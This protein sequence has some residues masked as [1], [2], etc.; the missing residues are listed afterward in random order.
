MNISEINFIR[1]LLIKITTNSSIK[2]ITVFEYNKSEGILTSF[3]RHRFDLTSQHS[4]Y[5]W[6][7]DREEFFKSIESNIEYFK[8]IGKCV[9]VYI[10]YSFKSQIFKDREKKFVFRVERFDGKRFSIKEIKKAR[11]II[12][13]EMKNFYI[14]DFEDL[15]DIYSRNINIAAFLG[16][17]FAR[18]IRE[19]E[20]FKFIIRVLEGFFAFDRI[21]LY[22]ID[23]AKNV[24]CGVYSID[25]TQRINDISYDVIAI[26]KGFS[27]LIDILMGEEDIVVKDQI[28][29][30]LP[31]KIDYK[32][33]GIIVVDNLLSQI[34]VKQHYIEL[35]KSFAPLIALTMENITLFEKMQ[36]MSMYDELTRLP[37]RRYFNQRF[38]EEFYR[39]S[40]FN[41]PLSLIWIDVDYFKE[42][43]DS[44]GHQIGDLVLVEIANTITRTIRKIDFPCRYGGDEIV[45]LLPQSNKDHAMGLGKRL[46][47]EIKKIKLDLKSYGIV[48]ELTLSVSMGI[49]SYP[50]DA[51]TMD[52]LLVKADEAL[53]WVKSRG[54]DGIAA[55]SDIKDKDK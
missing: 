31:L 45:I 53:Y 39:A 55:Y 25:K 18:S 41:Q 27:T 37:V 52:E 36:E 5:I 1:D 6:L 8:K 54:R 23:E 30:Y 17:T 11:K 19:K 7:K 35:L 32:K 46:I 44:F 24:L 12:E 40:R 13:E 49:S 34:P 28:M 22:R 33:V 42:I 2:N 48:K 51:K 47:E 15:K 50:D 10:P 38:S 20:G 16:K 9:F 26:K 3:L 4:E 43:N 21:R 14:V 29:I